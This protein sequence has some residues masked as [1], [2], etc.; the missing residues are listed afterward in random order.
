MPPRAQRIPTDLAAIIWFRHLG[1][2]SGI[3]NARRFFVPWDRC[4]QSTSQVPLPS[5]AFPLRKRRYT[6]WP[7]VSA[8][9]GQICGTVTVATVFLHRHSGQEF[10][11]FSHSSEQLAW[12]KWKH[13][14]V[15]TSDPT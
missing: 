3:R 8:A 2:L 11:R 5:G 15:R 13:G 1:T 12:K 4:P 6:I 14:S 7:S 9:G 10:S